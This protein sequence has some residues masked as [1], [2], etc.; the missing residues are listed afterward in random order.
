MYIYIYYYALFYIYKKLLNLDQYL[1][2]KR[3]LGDLRR[4]GSM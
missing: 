1:D 4:R 3:E 2:Q